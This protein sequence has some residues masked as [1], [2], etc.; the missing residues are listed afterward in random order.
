VTEISPGVDP[1]LW[2]EHGSVTWSL[3]GVVPQRDAD[4]MLELGWPGMSIAKT[5]HLA[6]LDVSDIDGLVTVVNRCRKLGAT[7]Y[8]QVGTAGRPLA[9][10]TC[11]IDV[12]LGARYG[13][14][15]VIAL[16]LTAVGIVLGL[17]DWLHADKDWPPLVFGT[18]VTVGLLV[19][20]SREYRRQRSNRRAPH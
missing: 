5:G 3:P 17:A 8:A 1:Q 10:D 7:D 20:H 14:A 11:S 19:S 16:A 18:V 2:V 4:L 13:V 9:D 12:S 6:F 15:V